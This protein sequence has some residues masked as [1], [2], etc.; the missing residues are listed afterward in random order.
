[1]PSE[2]GEKSSSKPFDSAPADVQRATLSI[3][4]VLR[5]TVKRGGLELDQFH[6]LNMLRSKVAA[7]TLAIVRRKVPR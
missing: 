2:I 6:E 4:D 5:T 1:L 7:A 3:E